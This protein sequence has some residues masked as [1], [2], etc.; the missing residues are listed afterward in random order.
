MGDKDRRTSSTVRHDIGLPSD[1]PTPVAQVRIVPVKKPAPPDTARPAP[2][3]AGKTNVEGREAE[4]RAEIERLKRAL[5]AERN[6]HKLTQGK[7]TAKKVQLA[8]MTRIAASSCCDAKSIIDQGTET[9]LEAGSTMWACLI[10]IHQAMG[11]EFSGPAIERFQAAAATLGL[12]I[13]SDEKIGSI[14]EEIFEGCKSE[15]SPDDPESGPLGDRKT[16]VGHQP[17]HGK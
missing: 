12:N 3:D 14:V 7:L 8:R 13:A 17:P 2:Q 11:I 1:A 10:E 5:A 9:L 6:A 4:L 16:Q 15:P